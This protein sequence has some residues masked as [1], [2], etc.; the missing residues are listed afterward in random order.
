MGVWKRKEW[1][2]DEEGVFGE[3]RKTIGMQWQCDIM[4]LFG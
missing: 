2:D 1:S 3:I 4:G